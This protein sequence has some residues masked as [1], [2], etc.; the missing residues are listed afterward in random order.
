MLLLAALL[1]PVANA[2]YPF[3]WPAQT[4]IAPWLAAMQQLPQM[5]PAPQ[6]EVPYLIWAVPQWVLVPVMPPSQESQSWPPPLPPV[7]FQ[8]MEEAAPVA[9]P[10]APAEQAPAAASAR[11][12]ATQ[13]E[14]VAPTPEVVKVVPEVKTT[15]ESA[16]QVTKPPRKK[17]V[18]ETV[19][20]KPSGAGASSET[21]VAKPRR[22]CWNNG[23]VDACPK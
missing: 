11:S 16:P 9:Q 10:G 1:S 3:M 14:P 4:L 8:S 5:A 12:D 13:P 15:T 21:S 2:Q 19:K 22:L 18:K 6:M 7:P 17:T 20:A 23:V